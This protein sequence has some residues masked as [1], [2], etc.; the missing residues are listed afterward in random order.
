MGDVLPPGQMQ[1]SANHQEQEDHHATSRLHP[2]QS[3]PGDSPLSQVL[4]RNSA[5]QNDLGWR[6]RINVCAKANRMLG[7]LGRNLKVC[8]VK[9]KE[10]AYKALIRPTAEYACAAWEPH[11]DK[12]VS[13]LEKVQRRAARLMLNRHR[14]TSSVGDVLQQL[15]WSTLQHRRWTIRLTMC[16]TRSPPVKHVQGAL[17][18]NGSLQ[19]ASGRSH[20]SLQYQCC[21]CHADYRSSTFFPRSQ[22]P[23]QTP[24]QM[25]FCPPPL[26]PSGQRY[27]PPP[28]KFP[29]CSSFSSV[30]LSTHELQAILLFLKTNKNNKCS[31]ESKYTPVLIFLL[32]S[33]VTFRFVEVKKN[34]FFF[35]TN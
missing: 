23:E 1:S 17:N 4:G 24:P 19:P 9:I 16:C 33:S 15:K 26:A 20:H 12:H 32:F 6:T 30:S 3:D 27:H 28:S 18:S 13:N 21:S 8:S 5:L 7:F 31:K 14:K 35:L 29:N 25:Q 22:G 34:F 11:N 2:P 10:L